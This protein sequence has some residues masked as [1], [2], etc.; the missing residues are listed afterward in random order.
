MSQK[1]VEQQV[2][3]VVGIADHL[4]I[5][6]CQLEIRQLFSMTVPDPE[7][8]VDK[9]SGTLLE[10]VKS[11]IEKTQSP[12]SDLV[13][14]LEADLT[15]KVRMHHARNIEYQLIPVRFESTQ[16]MNY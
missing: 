13:A 10:A 5:S 4:S 6:F 14:G 15:N 11:A 7:A 16:S 12:W 9:V 8:S 1:S 2:S 3:T